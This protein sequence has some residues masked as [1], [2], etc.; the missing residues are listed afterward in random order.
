MIC[1]AYNHISYNFGRNQDHL[2]AA[3]LYILICVCFMSLRPRLG[4]VRGVCHASAGTRLWLGGGVDLCCC[5]TPACS[6]RTS[7]G[8]HPHA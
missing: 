8:P 1:I 6:H 5:P 3:I 2:C 4:R 7:T